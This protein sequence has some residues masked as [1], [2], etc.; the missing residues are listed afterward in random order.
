MKTFKEF[1]E[2]VEEDHQ[3]DANLANLIGDETKKLIQ[4]VRRG[5]W[6]VVKKA[7]SNI[8]KLIK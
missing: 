5:K 4:A 2:K 6:R 8:G 1:Q 7:Y 3:G